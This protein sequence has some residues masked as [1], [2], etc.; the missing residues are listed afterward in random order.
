MPTSLGIGDGYPTGLEKPGN[1]R[2][3]FTR[4]I[5]SLVAYSDEEP[6]DFLKLHFDSISSF[7]YL[8]VDFLTI[9]EKN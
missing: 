4:R 1:G 9:A 2:Y 3:F 7:V 8:R 6:S 5:L